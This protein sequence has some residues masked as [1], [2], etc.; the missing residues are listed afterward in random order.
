[1]IRQDILEKQVKSSYL[2]I[3]SNLGDKYANI[4][5]AKNLLL[6]NNIYIEANSSYYETE[7]WPNKNFPK[8]FPIFSVSTLTPTTS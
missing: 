5:K 8:F 1:M 2:A 6:Q 4:E 7:S 3:G